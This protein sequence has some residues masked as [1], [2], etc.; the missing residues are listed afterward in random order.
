MQWISRDIA[1]VVPK[2]ITEIDKGIVGQILKEI[3]EILSEQRLVEVFKKTL[4]TLQ[5]KKVEFA[6]KFH[7]KYFNSFKSLFDNYFRFSWIIG[8]AKICPY[9]LTNHFPKEW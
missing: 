1:E 9:E 5:I 8:S 4:K 2:W 3:S 7:R 6:N